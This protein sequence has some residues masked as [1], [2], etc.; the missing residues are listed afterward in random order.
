MGRLKE[1]EDM[2]EKQ[3]RDMAKDLLLMR[4]G[5]AEYEMDYSRARLTGLKKAL[6]PIKDRTSN[7]NRT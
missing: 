1:I 3:G 7:V 5:H 4:I 2:W 6:T